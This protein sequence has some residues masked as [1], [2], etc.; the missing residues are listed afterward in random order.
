MG[1][2]QQLQPTWLARDSERI[3]RGS[4]KNKAWKHLVSLA[5]AIDMLHHEP[6]SIQSDA[7]CTA[8]SWECFQL[9]IST[10]CC[11]EL[12]L[13]GESYLVGHMHLLLM[14][15]AGV[16]SHI[17]GFHRIKLDCILTRCMQGDGAWEPK[18]GE[19]GAPLVAH[20]THQNQ[21]TKR[22]ALLN[23]A[24]NNT[25]SNN[26]SDDNVGSSEDKRQR[27]HQHGHCADTGFTADASAP[28]NA[29]SQDAAAA[30]DPSSA[31]AKAD[32]AQ[33]I[34]ES[35]VLSRLEKSESSGFRAKSRAGA[36]AAAHASSGDS[37]KQQRHDPQAF[38]AKPQDA[39]CDPQG[40]GSD[41][42]GAD[43][44]DRAVPMDIAELGEDQQTVDTAPVAATEDG[45]AAQHDVKA[46]TAL[47]DQ[48]ERSRHSS[49]NAVSKAVT[50]RTD[51]HP[52][53]VKAP[54]A[55]TP[56]AGTAPDPKHMA[57][58]VMKD[59]AHASSVGEDVHVASNATKAAVGRL[60]KGSKV[61]SV[62]DK[63]GKP[64]PVGDQDSKTAALSGMIPPDVETPTC[65]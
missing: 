36:R 17:V 39:A 15:L 59:D 1:F 2:E 55:A 56:A 48:L 31:Q 53:K 58:S 41:P 8:T 10:C 51:R 63:A 37:N 23:G 7:A 27:D 43:S 11:T 60:A 32:S 3:W 28:G 6:C 12:K 47:A 65:S 4:Y 25:S 16:V 61:A 26:D 64:A 57:E 62:T 35:G 33:P 9:G 44:A 18:S 29:Q 24:S 20:G 42:Q 38:E 49:K 30:Q 40:A 34:S 19:R 21:Y 54:A 52:Q 14:W 22:K 45:T 46:P 5:I 13:I 50:A